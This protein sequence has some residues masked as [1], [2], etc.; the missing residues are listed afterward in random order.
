[1][2]ELW[3]IYPNP[4]II[5]DASDSISLASASIQ[6]DNNGGRLYMLKN[7]AEVFRV[8]P[9]IALKSNVVGLA[10]QPVRLVAGDGRLYMIKNESEVWIVMPSLERLFDIRR[11]YSLDFAVADNSLYLTVDLHRRD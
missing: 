1:M 3:R 8:A 5:T 9:N 10:S 11:G 6:P 7:G 2:T 4:G